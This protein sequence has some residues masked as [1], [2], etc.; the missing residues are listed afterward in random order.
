MVV[1]DWN[2]TPGRPMAFARNPDCFDDDE[3]VSVDI[4]LLLLYLRW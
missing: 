2:S 3:D 4:L 1:I